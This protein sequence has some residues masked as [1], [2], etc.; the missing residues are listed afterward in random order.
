MNEYNNKNSLS[1]TITDFTDTLSSWVL[2]PAEALSSKPSSFVNTVSSTIGKI[3]AYS[4]FNMLMSIAEVNPSTAIRMKSILRHL[5][6]DM[7]NGI[8]GVPSTM[9]FILSYPEETLIRYAVPVSYGVSKLT[10]NRGAQV[11]IPGKPNF[12]FDYDIDIYVNKFDY[13]NQTRYSLYA[14]YNLESLDNGD[15]F[16]VA[17]PFIPSRNDVVMD[18]KR[19]L[20]MFIPVRQYERDIKYYELSGEN[21]D[22]SITFANQLVG[23]TVLY[24]ELADTSWSR[25]KVYPEGTSIYDGVLYSVNEVNE[26]KTLNIKFSKI[27]NTF[28]P[29]NG[30]L[31]INVFTT[32]GT[33][34]N[35]AIP[36][37]TDDESLSGLTMTL[38]QD[39]S[40]TYQ[41]AL[42]P[43]IP[44]GSLNTM[45]A[46]G[47]RDALSIEEVRTLV[48]N[49]MM[50]MIITPSALDQAAREVGFSE[51]KVRH[52]LLEWNYRLSKSLQDSDGNII[53]S[54]TIDS[55]FLFSE[56][57]NNVETNS[58]VIAP[59][60][61]FRYDKINKEYKYISMA[62]M[63]SYRDYI[64]KYKNDSI[65]DYLFPYFLRIQNGKRVLIEAYDLSINQYRTTEFVY[66]SDNILDKTSIMDVNFIRNPLDT[67]TIENKGIDNIM[68]NFYAIY[69]TVYTS[70]VLIDHLKSLE[71][72]QDAYVKFRIIIKNK[73]DSSVYMVD[74]KREDF[75]YD[76]KN[77]SIQCVGFI[78]TNNAI[79]SNGR[80]CM[81]NNSLSKIPYSSLD[82][83][84]YF[85]DGE[86]DTEFVVLFKEN[87]NEEHN[88]ASE[89][90]SYITSQEL[91]DKYYIGIIYRV[92][93]IVLAKNVSKHF[94]LNN[95]IKLTQPIYKITDKDITDVYESVVYKMEN[96]SYVIEEETINL[97]DG[98]QQRIDKFVILHNKGDIKKEV[99]GRVGTYDM[100]TQSTIW[101]NEEN[102]EGLYNNGNIL[103][104]DSIYSSIKTNDGLLIFAGKEGR[105]GCYDTEKKIW[106]PYN[107]DIVW[108]D[109]AVKIPVIKNDGSA[110]NFKDIRTMEIVQVR[111]S[112]NNLVSVLVVAGDDGNVASCNLINGQWKFFD[113]KGGDSAAYIYNNGAAMGLSAI[114][115]SSKYED[116]N[117]E[118]NNSL[119]FAGGDG[120]ICSY[121]ISKKTWY[122]WDGSY[123]G[124]GIVSNDG[125]STGYKAILTMSN[126]LNNILFF[127]GVL[128]H[129][130]SFEFS[131]SKFTNFDSLSGIHSNGEAMG[132]VSIYASNIINATLILAGEEGRVANY[133]IAKAIWTRYDQAGLASNGEVVNNKN[134][135]AIDLYDNYVIFGS[136]EGH[137]ASYN[138]FTNSWTPYNAPSGIRNNGTFIKSSISSIINNNLII[139]FSGKAGNVI[140][141]YKAGDILIDEN[142][143]FVV[144]RPSE[145][146]GI[147]KDL[148]VYD[149][150]YAVKSS[151]FNILDSY[152]TMINEV[153]GLATKFPQGCK[154]TLGIK[155]TSG[156][157][158]TF[159]FVNIKTKEEEYIN[160][161]SLSLSLGVRFK[162][163]ILSEDKKYLVQEIII[164]CRKYIKEIQEESSDKSVRLNFGTMLDYIK[165]KVPN[166]IYF[167]IYNINGYD[168]NICQ[169]IFWEKDI[170]D[171]NYK[172]D[173]YL[174]IRSNVDEVVSDISK[175]IVI[176]TPAIEVT[177]L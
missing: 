86:V 167:E 68:G 49:R 169:T 47:G 77:N 24:K 152:N 94:L 175:Q 141:K 5:K 144:D 120:R 41:E 54:R 81:V 29:E 1:A 72:D 80:V 64:D 136:D 14:M 139:Y 165:S 82:Y 103:G 51:E 32:N 157:S 23:F 43:L 126:Y 114:Y 168:A 58:R 44:T 138:I 142:G 62:N 22:I 84:F 143:N 90:D 92:E 95:D 19:Y 128:G 88:N 98:S 35:F 85:I 122:P 34:G 27:P 78:E 69:F 79:L 33:K 116:I 170:I 37:I 176:F 67:D 16:K 123:V 3:N 104:E 156:I 73:T 55:T 140:Y 63:D 121:N 75:I 50:N 46:D 132:A 118:G 70:N 48:I 177:V 134:I 15:L 60:D 96:G 115:C 18:N 135:N 125:A 163:N 89:Y 10:L 171:D 131:I 100:S 160:N 4:Y 40:S 102:E 166:I 38:S 6:S 17:N 61:T 154:L 56:I 66:I 162:D 113:G 111:D 99:D 71:E 91:L 173:E 36:S 147:I 110:T 26:I 133:D 137:V 13:N 172:E 153:I 20:T 76:T 155:N 28:R 11:I 149:R 9:T 159:K 31:K 129:V 150:I 112:S 108:R 2:D 52:D 42:L 12:T 117:N 148:P 57:P 127:S 161:L 174:S 119:V 164:E 151:Y 74:V 25:V 65:N 109:E 21:K 53:P 8:Y 83:P 87:E 93:N 105:V 45:K 39:T 106:Y 30:T 124:K 158:S 97:P 101:S 146:Q 7:I 130:S 59:H 145:L 107:S